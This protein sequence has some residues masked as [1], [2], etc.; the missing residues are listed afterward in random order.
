M[1][2]Y[3]GSAWI[4]F[5]SSGDITA[6]TAGTGLSGGGTSGSVTLSLDTTSVYVVPSQSGQS[7]KYLTTDGSVTSW[8]SV[9]GYSAPTLG[10]TTISSG[11]TVTNVNGLTINSTTIPTSKTLVDTDSSQTLTN[12]TISGSSNTLTNIGNASLTN[13]SITINGSSVSLGGSATISGGADEQM[14]V[15]GAY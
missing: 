2:V 8:G 11:A 15:M 10:S 13:S 1:Y 5:T 7:G 4:V 6:V 14:V 12:K 9:S 3:S